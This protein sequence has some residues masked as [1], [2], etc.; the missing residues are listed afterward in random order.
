MSNTF[1]K[2]QVL[3]RFN[4][5][6]L[7]IESFS[8]DAIIAE[9][10]KIKTRHNAS[11]YTFDPIVSVECDKLH[12][13]IPNPY[14]S[15]LTEGAV[16]VGESHTDARCVGVAKRHYAPADQEEEGR[17]LFSEVIA[18]LTEKAGYYYDRAWV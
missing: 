4:S 2:Y 16:M 10:H 18:D 6:R 13:L 9:I 8:K 17:K 3:Y 11:Q 15:F 7:T 12:V 5:T 1:I 14:R